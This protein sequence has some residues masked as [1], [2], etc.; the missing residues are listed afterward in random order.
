VRHIKYFNVVPIEIVSSGITNIITISDALPGRR[1]NSASSHISL[2]WPTSTSDWLGALADAVMPSEI[3]VDRSVI[4]KRNWTT[5]ALPA[6][7]LGRGPF[8]PIE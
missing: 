3:G 4:R 1:D 5:A 2:D 8:R 6:P 7:A